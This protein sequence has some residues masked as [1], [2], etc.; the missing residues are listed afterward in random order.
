MKK[1]LFIMLTFTI[2]LITHY[3]INVY[4]ATE[5][6]TTYSEIMMSEGKLLMNFTDEEMDKMLEE[7][8]GTIFSGVKVYEEN[9]NVKATYI[10][11][12]LYSVEN[13]G[14]TD[15]TYDVV[16]SVE[17][18]NKVSFSASGSLSGN[19][20]KGKSGGL[21][22]D[23]G[24]KCSVDYSNDTTT[25][26]KEKQTMKLVVE[27]NSRA[28]VYLTG[29]LLI[30]NGVAANYFFWIKMCEGGFEFVTLQNQY[31]RIEKVKISW[32]NGWY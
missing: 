8:E 25:S 11:N 1:I 5:E 20:S 24:A 7:I 13:K 16:V 31:S 17:T 4:A 28:I 10:S 32:E 30:T 6:Y 14:S 18:T 26:R 27:A 29:E 19:V 9:S 22:G 15:V 21:K 12:T 23:I 3:S 2:L